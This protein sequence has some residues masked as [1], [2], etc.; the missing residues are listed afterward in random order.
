MYYLHALLCT[1]FAELVFVFLIAVA[2]FLIAAV[3][4]H[5]EPQLRRVFNTPPFNAT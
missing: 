3:T 4:T 1:Q 2:I 5:L